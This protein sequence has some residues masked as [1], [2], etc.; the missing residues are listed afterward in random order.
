MATTINELRA[1]RA[2]AWE[3][4]KAFLESHRTEKGIL[5]AEDDAT[6]TKMEGDI[7]ALGKEIKRLERQ[8][9]IENELNQPTS[10]P[11]TAKPTA[12]ICS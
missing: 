1:K 12:P 10:Q 9:E 5:S 2:Q 8:Q 3:A 6:Y 11:L 7:D 4:A